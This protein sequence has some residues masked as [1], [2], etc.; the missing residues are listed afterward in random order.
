[1]SASTLSRPSSAEPRELATALA[2]LRLWAVAGQA[3]TVFI[4]DRG[5]RLDV[6]VTPL[7]GGI[8]VLAAFA[9]FALWRLQQPWPVGTAEAVAHIAVDTAVLG[10]LLYFSGGATNPFVS[11][12][13][14]PITLA[15]SALGFRAVAAVAGLSAL[16]YA[17]LLRWYQPLP[18][19]HDQHG[20]FGRHV[21]GMAVSFVISAAT[22]GYFIG[23]LAR[24]LRARREEVQRVRERALRD[25]GI[26]AIATQAAGAA[27]ELNT[28]LSTMRTLLAE[29][30][31]EHPGGML[32]EDIT[33]LESQVERCRD[34][35]RELV[36][37]GQAQLSETR[38]TTMLGAFVTSCLDRFRLLRP[39]ADVTLQVDE[40]LAAIPLALPPGLRHALL[41]LLN[42]AADASA[43]RGETTLAFAVRRTAGRI[44]FRV[45]DR[46]PGPSAA[47]RATLGRAFGTTKS[48]GLGLG[49]ALADATAERLGG[50]LELHATDDGAETVFT[51]PVRALLA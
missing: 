10:W 28:P 13:L 9:L 17:V 5:M 32:G 11:L 35:L 19:L 33:V 38:E 30:K 36:A 48:T 40:S 29:L 51:I 20:D 7:A 41:N 3:L 18:N 46:G 16:T 1:M 34:S 31:R 26:L 23:R 39:E 2:Y 42:N 6:P 8:A 43:A 45:R 25:E 21:I 14:M 47:A 27:H 44:E 37:V 24:A 49:F 4:V 50:R 22:L 12:L 15:A